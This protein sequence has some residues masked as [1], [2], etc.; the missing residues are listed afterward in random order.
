[1][2]CLTYKLSSY[3]IIVSWNLAENTGVLVG[4]QRALLLTARVARNSCWF[5]YPVLTHGGLERDHY[6]CLYSQWAV[7]LVGTFELE[8]FIAFVMSK[9]KAALW[10]EGK[11]VSS[12]LKVCLLRNDSG[13]GSQGLAFLANLAKTCRGIQGSQQITF[14]I[15]ATSLPYKFLITQN[16]HMSMPL[17]ITLINLTEETGTKSVLFVSQSILAMITGLQALGQILVLIDSYI[18]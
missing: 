5:P 9:K 15:T 18:P 4:R 13:K 12:S 7:L 11:N 3:P 17:S 8:G 14:S 2:F 10:G 16:F 6:R 1:M